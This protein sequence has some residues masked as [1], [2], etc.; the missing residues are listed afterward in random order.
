MH[1]K[2][3]NFLNNKVVLVEMNEVEPCVG[4]YVQGFFDENMV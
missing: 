3:T 1:V 4:K 2:I